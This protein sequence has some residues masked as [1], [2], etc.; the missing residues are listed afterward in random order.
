[1][2]AVGYVNR[3]DKGFEDHLRTPTIN[4]PVRIVPNGV[5][6]EY[7]TSV[8]QGSCSPAPDVEPVELGWRL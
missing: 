4:A 2:P 6:L 1:M 7:Y 3:T 5:D 8:R